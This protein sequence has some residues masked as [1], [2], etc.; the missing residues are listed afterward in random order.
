MKVYVLRAPACSGGYVVGV[1]QSEELAEKAKL[2]H[3]VR[4]GVN[5]YLD[6]DEM[7]LVCE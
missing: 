1:Y 4:N 6:I 3:H 2:E 5:L 7:E